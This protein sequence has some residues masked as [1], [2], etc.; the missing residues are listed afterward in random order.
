MMLK[1]FRIRHARLF[2][3]VAAAAALSACV[4]GPPPPR[5][6][7][8]PPRPNVTVYAYP[9]QG[10]TPEQQDRDRYECSNWATQQTG[11]NPSAPNVPPHDRV[12]VVSTT[13]G[14]GRRGGCRDGR[15]PRRAAVS[16]PRNA[17]SRPALLGALVGGALGA[18]AEASANA[19]AQA[20]AD[21]SVNARTQAQAAQI[22]RKAS[23][24]R[25]AIGACLGR[26]RLQRSLEETR[27]DPHNIHDP[28]DRAG[29]TGHRGSRLLHPGERGSAR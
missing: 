25:R 22:E 6:A 3:V 12:R 17:R 16:N 1:P 19:Q 24:Y 27:N 28:R 18:G 10:Q 20:Q 2:A 13:P 7:P 8:P 11:F 14:G 15:H 21:A 29:R 23:D 4:V 26:P 9:Q 5:P